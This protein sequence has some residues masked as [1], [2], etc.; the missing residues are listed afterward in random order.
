MTRRSGG[1]RGAKPTWTTTST[2]GIFG[3]E[4]VVDLKAAGQWPRGPVAPTN[5]AATAG[6][7]Q[8][9]LT[10]TAPATP[11]GTITNYLVE[12]TPSGGSPTVVATGSTAASY[13][14][15]G[16]TNGTAYTFRVAAVNH[17]VGDYSGTVS[18]TPASTPNFSALTNNNPS[19]PSSGLFVHAGTHNGRPYFARYTNG[20]PDLYLY[21]IDVS[22]D[23]G[24]WRVGT[25][26]SSGTTWWQIIRYSDPPSALPPVGAVPW[27]PMVYGGD[28]VLTQVTGT[29]VAGT[30]PNAP[31]SLTATA[32][33]AQLSLSWTAP[34]APGTSA[35]TGY[36]VEYTPSGGAAATVNTNSTSTSYTLTGL[37]NG[38]SYAVRVAAI[39]AVGT[40]TYSAAATGTPGVVVPLR[41]ARD[42]A[43]TNLV[44][45]TGL[46]TAASPFEYTNPAAN[47]DHYLLIGSSGT[48]NF[49]M[50]HIC[51]DCGLDYT[52]NGVFQNWEPNYDV[53]RQQNVLAVTAGQVIVVRDN[54]ANSVFRAFLS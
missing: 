18:A 8:V 22:S 4:D 39:S 16:L 2:S 6:N 9:A 37:T 26:L 27:E 29:P 25:Q 51:P 15:T 17:T 32:G 38:T 31:T 5:L 21:W 40:G 35:I 52:F 47:T 54:E 11:Y 3:M 23:A 36:V 45:T 50:R 14:V 43:G 13:T 53:W 20:T 24:Y 48:L 28:F 10:W 33:N 7:A 41:I 12:Y 34:S 42:A 44:S 46:G 19:H 49:R 1:F 30:P